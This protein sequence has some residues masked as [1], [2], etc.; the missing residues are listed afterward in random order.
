MPTTT[1][2]Q[3]N[4]YSTVPNVQNAERYACPYCTSLTREPLLLYK[5][6][7]CMKVS[8]FV[9]AR[10]PRACPHC[11]TIVRTLPRELIPAPRVAVPFVETEWLYHVT[12]DTIARAVKR[13]GLR[14]AFSRTGQRIPDASGSF[15]LDRVKRIEGAIAGRIMQY[16]VT[17]LANA[18]NGDMWRD[19]AIPYTPFVHAATGSNDDYMSLSALEKA[20]LLHFGQ[21][22]HG[23]K[24]TVTP[25][26]T[27]GIAR[28][29]STIA[30][31]QTLIEK[32][33]H[34]LTKLATQSANFD[35][36]VEAAITSSHV[37]FLNTAL[38]RLTFESGYKDYTKLRSPLSIVV[39]RVR[40]AD[41]TGLEQDM[42]DFRAVR[43]QSDVAAARLQ[44][45]VGT[46]IYTE[47]KRLDVRS[48]DDNW[49]P[50]TQ[51]GA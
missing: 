40:R 44:I 7:S 11:M 1:C 14:S 38:D 48:R 45:L 4:R 51:W 42:A 27:V 47:F 18:D 43:T 22:V 33:D 17:C 10:T 50:L 37:Y 2:P 46:A 19:A 34:Y 12:T 39:L 6:F 26:G 36:N 24:F 31:R 41:V 3:C 21:Q 16:L 20:S 29:Q 30:L 13:Q 25:R 5:C 15:A 35:F 28:K 49:M 9:A 8:I 23:P 32:P